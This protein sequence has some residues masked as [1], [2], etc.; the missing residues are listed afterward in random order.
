MCAC[1]SSA[2]CLLPH[3]RFA[4]AVASQPGHTHLLQRGRPCHARVDALLSQHYRPLAACACTSRRDRSHLWPSAHH[5]L[6]PPFLWPSPVCTS[7]ST[8]IHM[9]PAHARA[10]TRAHPQN[11]HSPTLSWRCPVP[12]PPAFIAAAACAR[13]AQLPHVRSE[14]AVYN[15][16]DFCSVR[17][18]YMRLPCFASTLHLVACMRKAPGPPRVARGSTIGGEGG[19]G[20]MASSRAARWSGCRAAAAAAAA[21]AACL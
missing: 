8:H 21:A 4:P 13:R 11:P 9:Q 16:P 3:A 14:R 2:R 19:G 6:P 1:H 18:L 15:L 20:W 10:R 17:P 12:H 5:P 7:P